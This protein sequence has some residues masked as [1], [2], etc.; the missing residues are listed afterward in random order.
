MNKTVKVKWKIILTGSRE[1][2]AWSYIE[3]LDKEINDLEER[4]RKTPHFH[5]FT[6]GFGASL[7]SYYLYRVTGQKK[8]FKRAH[9]FIDMSVNAI[10]KVSVGDQLYSGFTGTAWLVEHIRHTSKKSWTKKTDPNR[11]IDEYLLNKLKSG[12]KSKL[13]LRA[14]GLVDDWVGY[15]VYGIERLDHAKTSAFIRQMVNFLKIKSKSTRDGTSWYTPKKFVPLEQKAEYK[16]G[17][18]NIGVAHGVPG[19]IGF[20]GEVLKSDSKNKL[21]R[22]LLRSAIEWLVHQDCASHYGFQIPPKDA[23]DQLKQKVRLAWCYGD[24]GISIVLLNVSRI[25]RD[26]KLEARAM[27]IATRSSLF[28]EV[29]SGIA[30]PYFCHGGIGAFHGFN[31]LYQGTNDE[32]FLENALKW[33]DVTF[34]LIEK[35]QNTEKEFNLLTGKT[36]VG[37]SL[38]AGVSTI[39]PEWDRFLLMS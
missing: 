23:M 16:N 6:A 33:V 12:I 11:E 36:G 38:L 20:L 29:D 26:P 7:F 25:L 28:T 13:P 35:S 31:R 17:Y 15:G 5:L 24:L 22:D 4:F 14:Y 34:K 8:Y 37:I 2:A 9:S 1:R 32:I 18:F 30:D 19:V 3:K 10:G 21:V 27:E 39:T